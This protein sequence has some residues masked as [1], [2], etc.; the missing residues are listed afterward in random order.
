M[1]LVPHFFIKYSVNNKHR[2]KCNKCLTLLTVFF[3][4][5]KREIIG[6]VAFRTGM[7]DHWK[8]HIGNV[9]TRR[10]NVIQQTAPLHTTHA[11]NVAANDTQ[12]LGSRVVSVLDCI[13]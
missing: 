7:T 9:E 5:G 12:W 8:Y 2:E 1:S 4:R 11:F 6:N 10:H 13:L 3:C